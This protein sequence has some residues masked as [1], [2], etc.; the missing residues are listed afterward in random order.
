[1]KEPLVIEPSRLTFS[2]VKAQSDITR[3]A[4]FGDLGVGMIGMFRRE[5]SILLRLHPACVQVDMSGLRLIDSAGVEVLLSFFKDLSAQGGRV[6]VR[7]LHDQPLEVFKLMLREA[8]GPA[9]EVVN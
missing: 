6:V 8:I 4:I 3:V 9:S 7:G 2:I 1:V 5:L